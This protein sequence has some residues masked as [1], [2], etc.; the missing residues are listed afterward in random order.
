MSESI[1]LFLLLRDLSERGR[2]GD[3]VILA[4]EMSPLIDYCFVVAI[5]A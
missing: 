4:S 1:L 2:G 5:P 3:K